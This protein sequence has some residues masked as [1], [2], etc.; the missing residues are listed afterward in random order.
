M[1][2]SWTWAAPGEMCTSPAENFVPLEPEL[3]MFTPP[4]DPFGT[5][6]IYKR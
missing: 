1:L 2:F 5:E 6:T 4:Y 3:I